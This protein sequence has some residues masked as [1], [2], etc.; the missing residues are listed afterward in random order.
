MTDKS[1]EPY[2]HDELYRILIRIIGDSNTGKTCLCKCF[3]GEEFEEVFTPTF[4]LDFKVR[5]VELDG[6]KVKLQL[7]D[8]AG[9]E[10]YRS[11]IAPGMV[12]NMYKRANGVIVTYNVTKEDTFR[13]V[14]YWIEEAKKSARPDVNLMIVGT[15]CDREDKKVDYITARDF[16]NEHQ[17]SFFEVSAK[18][19]TNVELAFVT[20]IEEIKQSLLRPKLR[21]LI[22]KNQATCMYI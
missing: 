13:N 18:D 9:N 3:T 20:F 15:G 12:Y 11:M 10:R 21:N 16:A 17:L 6:V 7:W 2:A 19:G 4:G 5:T 8:T 14:P 22:P 1:S